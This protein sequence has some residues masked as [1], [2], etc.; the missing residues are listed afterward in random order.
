ME[1][2]RRDDSEAPLNL[3]QLVGD[4]VRLEVGDVPALP[5]PVGDKAREQD[6]AD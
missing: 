5:D 2:V 3:P 6:G 1:A 4:T